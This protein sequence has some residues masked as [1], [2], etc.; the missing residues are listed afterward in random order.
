MHIKSNIIKQDGQNV[1]VLNKK[2]QTQENTG[3]LITH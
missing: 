3:N 1:C 2:I